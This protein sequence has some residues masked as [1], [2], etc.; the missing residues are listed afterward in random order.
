MN[1]LNGLLKIIEIELRSGLT[2]FSKETWKRM[3]ELSDWDYSIVQSFVTHVTL[4]IKSGDMNF[5]YKKFKQDSIVKNKKR[6]DILIA[7]LKRNQH[8]L[9]LTDVI[10]RLVMPQGITYKYLEVWGMEV[11][12]ARN[13]A[14]QRSFEFGCDYILFIDDDMIVE[15]TAFIKLWKLMQ[16]TKKL[17]VSADYQKKADYKV[18]AHG[19]F[20]DTEYGDHI[21]ETDLCAMGFT[22]ININEISKKVPPPYFFIFKAPDGLWGMGEDAFFS[23]NFIEY[24]NEKPLIDC[25]ISVLHYDKVWKRLFGERDKNLTYAS[26]S[27]KTFEEFDHIRVPP[28]YPLINICIP[29]RAEQDPISTNLDRLLTLRG[30]KTE[31]STIHGLNVDQARNELAV[32]SVKL[33][34]EFTLFIDNDIIMP[35]N[36]I[37]KMLEVMESDKKRTIGMVV[38]DYLLKGKIP[39]S[40][41]LQLDERGVVTELNRIE[42]IPDILDSNWLVGLGCA[43]IRTEVFRQVQYPYFMCISKK[44]NRIGV[45][46]EEDGGVNEDAYFTEALFENGYKVKIINDLKCVHINF[47]SGTMFG[48]DQT[49]DVNKYACFDWIDQI[50]YKNINDI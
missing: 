3:S 17:V 11:D 19:N 10:N 6:Y 27:V 28:S 1:H 25:N 39:H 47:K 50:K 40:V 15:N 21:K 12:Q 20:F 45:D 13:Y 18:T 4:S 29:K 26:N 31:F 43:L 34:S 48:Y 16:D 41:H 2:S 32:N 42:N 36:A 23:N 46:L 9:I 30:Y 38:G 22:L 49:F 8:D 44:M 35:E 37:V 5:V 24:C 7:C 33:N 14:V